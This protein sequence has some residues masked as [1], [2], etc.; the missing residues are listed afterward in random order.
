MGN[1]W[2]I[3]AKLIIRAVVSFVVLA[4]ASY[5]ILSG[6]YPDSYAM[7]AFGVIGVIIGYWLR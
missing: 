1:I 3:R 5:I 7:W 2:L 6:R 4:A